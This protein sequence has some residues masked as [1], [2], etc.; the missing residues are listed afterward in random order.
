[1]PRISQAEQMLMSGLNDLERDWQIAGAEWH[2]QARAHFQKDYL[3]EIQPAGRIAAG[4]ISELTTL[5]R[6]V[7]RECR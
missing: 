7:V 1:M 6:R 5:M 2:D 3:D 4:A